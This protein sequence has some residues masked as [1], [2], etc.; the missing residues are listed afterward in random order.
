M[1]VKSVKSSGVKALI[2]P[3]DDKFI[4][5]YH[6]K[7]AACCDLVA[8]IPK[9]EAGND[10][11]TIPYRK[12]ASVSCGFSLAVP[13]GFK[14]EIMVRSSFAKRGLV[15]VNGPGQIDSDYRGE[16]EVIVGNI[17][18]E[19]IQI[20]NGERFAQLALTPVYRFEWAKVDSLPETERGDGGFGS[21]GK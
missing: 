2:V 12:I 10:Y 6:S 13:K 20:K 17:G 11:I 21:T 5:M 16:V 7:E 8:N 4:P 14:A 9:N 1:K 19:I 15:V 3:I 18:Q